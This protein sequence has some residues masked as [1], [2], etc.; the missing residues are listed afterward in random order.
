TVDVEPCAE[1]EGI[2]RCAHNANAL[3]AGATVLLLQGG[4]PVQTVTAGPDGKFQFAH[5]IAD[6]EYTLRVIARDFEVYN[7]APF[8]YDHHGA[9][10]LLTAGLE[11]LPIHFRAFEQL[12]GRVFF[13]D[14]QTFQVREQPGVTL[15]A[16]DLGNPLYASPN[17]A[18]SYRYVG[19][20][21]GFPGHYGGPGEPEVW[22]I[23][24]EPLLSEDIWTGY[25]F[26]NLIAVE[27]GIGTGAG[28]ARSAYT[29]S[30]LLSQ[31]FDGPGIAHN[32]AV[33][34]LEVYS[35]PNDGSEP[36][37]PSPTW[38][39]PANLIQIGP[40]PIAQPDPGDVPP[41]WMARTRFLYRFKP[42]FFTVYGNGSFTNVCGMQFAFRLHPEGEVP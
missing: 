3:A 16:S 34:G 36:A 21:P 13:S 20:I 23:I 6:G 22:V 42:G 30:T 39:S 32:Y 18:K 19:A 40:S 41:G 37:N 2:A 9:N 11:P 14:V 28:R 17:S 27:D 15:G 29:V 38:S 25:S 24:Q 33:T 8:S 12:S 1:I 4:S 31:P 7:S 26:T 10:V 5:P 35:T